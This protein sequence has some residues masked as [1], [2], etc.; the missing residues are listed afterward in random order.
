M[1]RNLSLITLSNIILVFSNALWIMYIQYFLL[2]LG[3]SKT[4]IG[5]IFTL[6]LL[7]RAFGNIIGG[8]IADI[9]GY[10]RTLLIG[11]GIYA[12]P[13]LLILLHNTLL[14]SLVY[15]LMSL[16]SGIGIP[17][18]SLFIVEQAQRRKGLTYMLVQRVLPSIPPALT[19]P[20][21]AKLYEMGKYDV[22]VFMGF[23]GLL[24]SLLLLV[25]LEDTKRQRV[26]NSFNFNLLRSKS[27]TALLF[28]YSLNAFSTEAVQWI[29]PL[30]LRELGY[31]V[32]DYG[33]LI[34]AQTLVIAFGG[35]FAGIFVD[36]FEPVNALSL[37]YLVVA[38]SLLA[39]S[40]GKG[41]ILVLAYLAWKAFGM[42][43]FAALPLIIEKYFKDMRAS[44]FGTINAM[45]TLISIPAPAFGGFLLG[46]GAGVPFVFKAIT[47]F[48]CFV[49]VKVSLSR[50]E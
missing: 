5:L 45:T 49:L 8:K 24:I 39:F 44:A 15:P 38:T 33:F 13:P 11:Y 26:Q 31:S 41:W 1:N 47:N 10:K 6:A 36:R 18:K 40:L 25:F 16:G 20:A 3:I 50:E 23:L 29:V 21:G 34:S 19:A 9:L 7:M 43:G 14:V 48:F 35:T 37:S 2:D 22:A 28:L 17:A 4:Q 27:F 46:S 42:V 32:L 12:F 30:Y